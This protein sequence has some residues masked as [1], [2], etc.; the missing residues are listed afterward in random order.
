VCAHIYKVCMLEGVCVHIY[1]YVLVH[2]SVYICLHIYVCMNENLH[3]CAY[4]YI[5]MHE[6]CVC[7]HIH[8]CVCLKVVCLHISTYVHMHEG[9]FVCTHTS[10]HAPLH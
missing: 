9:V 3:V 4:M 2:H 8:L 5:G 7:A 1:M 6:G 10:G